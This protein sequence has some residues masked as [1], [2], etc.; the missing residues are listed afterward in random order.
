MHFLG[1]FFVFIIKN[2]QSK[3]QN[4]CGFKMSRVLHIVLYCIIDWV[5]VCG[6]MFAS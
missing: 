5:F 2:A 1:L 4:I 3:K 6:F